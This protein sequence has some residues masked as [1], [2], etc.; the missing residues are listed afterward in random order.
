MENRKEFKDFTSM[1]DFIE[2]NNVPV[3]QTGMRGVVE[4]RDADNNLIFKKK[5]TIVLRG[6]T[7]VLEKLF[8][9]EIDEHMSAATATKD[10]YLRGL[11]RSLC[12]FS[13]GT[14]GTPSNSPFNPIPPG[15]DDQKLAAAAPFRVVY[16]QDF[17]G[18]TS[19][20]PT[21]PADI[22]LD[23]PHLKSLKA[24]SGF[25]NSEFYYKTF[26]S[27]TWGLDRTTNEVYRKIRLSIIEDD[28]RTIR[29]RANEYKRE[30]L[31]NELGLFMAQKN[32]DGTIN[33]T[34]ELFSRIT[35][36]SESLRSASITGATKEIYIDYYIFG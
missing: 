5:N 19:T 8:G 16:G 36:D 30:I 15:A 23:Y 1:V 9:T 32:V 14:G 31:I 13:C 26:D 24:S 10:A 21:L 3:V 17:G 2:K 22:A 27:L 7:F 28:F 4:F 12:L 18:T 25:Y 35:F 34:P 11:S 29:E 33:G 6:R 20:I